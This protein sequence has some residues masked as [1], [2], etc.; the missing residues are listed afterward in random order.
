MKCSEHK[1][2]PLPRDEAAPLAAESHP[3][4]RLD[5]SNMR[6]TNYF[7][8]LIGDYENDGDDSTHDW[9]DWHGHADRND[10]DDDGLDNSHDQ[11][12]WNEKA[13]AFDPLPDPDAANPTFYPR[14][15]TGGPKRRPYHAAP[16]TALQ[17]PE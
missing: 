8:P 3:L 17:M 14:Q 1:A 11:H 16:A 12:G 10:D 15:A 7:D 5:T 2:S 13:G 4:V 9:H 6:D